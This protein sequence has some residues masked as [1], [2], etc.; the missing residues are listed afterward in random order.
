MLEVPSSKVAAL[1][2]LGIKLGS[3]FEEADKAI[4]D[5]M[6]VLAVVTAVRTEASLVSG[7]FPP[8]SSGRMYV[9]ADKSEII[10][11]FDE[12]PAAP[13]NVLGVWRIVRQP[14]GAIAAAPL[15]AAL[16]DK[17]GE[18]AELEKTSS[19]DIEGLKFVWSDNAPTNGCDDV[20]R[21][22]IDRD[23]VIGSWQSQDSMDWRPTEYGRLD[24]PSFGNDYTG[25]VSPRHSLSTFCPPTLGVRYATRTNSTA[26]FDEVMTWFYDE[27]EY[28][29]Q[30]YRGL[31]QSADA[32]VKV[33][34]GGS[35]IKF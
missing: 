25:G 33:D 11:I 4:R 14:S 35:N 1:D 29:K 20:S 28:V 12:P 2:V 16:V 18:P 13:D 23:D 17:Y 19:Y 9:S 30:Y 22:N 5:H 31:D 32:Q 6:D 24:V 26:T 3:S 15:K 34:P 10:T 21:Y 27:R 8:W 7:D